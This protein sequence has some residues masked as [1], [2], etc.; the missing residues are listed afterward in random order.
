MGRKTLAKL[1]KEQVEEKNLQNIFSE[2][3][4]F[5]EKKKAEVPAPLINEISF[6]RSKF[7][8]PEESFVLKTKSSNRNKQ[9]RELVRHV[10]NK[11]PVPEFMYAVWEWEKKDIQGLK[12]CFDFKEWYICIAS[13]G[14]LYKEITKN[15]F[16]KKE[17]HLFLTCTFGLSLDESLVYS[18]AKAECGED[19]GSL[20]IAKSKIKSQIFNNYW[21]DNIRWFAKNLPDNVEAINDLIDYLI[22]KKNENNE[23]TLI[24][25]GLT[26]KSLTKKMHDWHYDLRRL[27]IIGDSYWDGLNIADQVYNYKD[28]NKINCLW[29]FYQIKN[30]KE[31]QREGNSQ[32]HCVLSYKQRCIKNQCSIWSL[33]TSF[34]WENFKD[35]KTKVTIEINDNNQIVQAKGLANRKMKPEEKSILEYWAKQNNLS[36]IYF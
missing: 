20:R 27:K 1:E 12:S 18:V 17:T 16:S 29:H 22:H 25:S 4:K 31:L 6:F 9:L 23:F 7:L 21:R 15:H 10:F 30:S 5:L 19:K 14:S 13:G 3:S 8:R 26:V 33:R 24:G 34:E 11:Y 2:K 28:E 36:L 35:A 32:R